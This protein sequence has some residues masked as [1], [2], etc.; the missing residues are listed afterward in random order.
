[1]TRPLV[2]I[3]AILAVAFAKPAAA[4]GLLVIVNPSVEIS[5]PLPLD[6]IAAIYLLR[7]TTWPDGSPIVPVNREA[8]SPQRQEFTARILREDDTALAAYWNQ[9]H[10]KGKFPPVVQ[11]SDQATLAFVQKVPGSIGYIDAAIAPVDVK[12]AAHV[13]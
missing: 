10:F 8:S 13:P 4:A 11:E 12:V 1:M 9:M 6:E 2:V 5:G 3:A 7:L